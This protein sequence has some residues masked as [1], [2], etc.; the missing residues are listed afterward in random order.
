MKYKTIFSLAATLGAAFLVSGTANAFIN[1]DIVIQSSNGFA[2]SPM[3]LKAEITP[4]ET[5]EG[6]FRVRSVADTTQDVFADATPYSVTN[7]QYNA[8]YS[9]VNYR[10]TLYKYA[11]ISLD[12]RGKDGCKITKTE[13]NRIYFTLRSQEECYVTY[14]IDVPLDIPAGSQY[15]SFGVQQV[16]DSADGSTGGVIRS[17]RIATILYAKNP[18]GNTFEK[19]ELIYQDI[20]KWVFSG[21]LKTTASL[22]NEG[23]I[24]FDVVSNIEVRNLFGSL[25]YKPEK[26]QTQVVMAETTRVISNDWSTPGVGIYRVSQTVK[27]LG[28]ESTIQKLVFCIP[29]WLIWSIVICLIV[30]IL[31]VVYGARK[32]KSSTYRR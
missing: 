10:N 7:D 27:Y 13:E 19:G 6:E 1:E 4:G 21:P 24:D 11:T 8:D 16:P 30:F 5:I 18:H 31:A 14:K 28:K 26:E 29:I 15:V 32:R 22:K 3:S 9:T 20:Q 2:L 17:N 12:D 23:N 25:I